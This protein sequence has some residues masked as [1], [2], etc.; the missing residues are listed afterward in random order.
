MEVSQTEK[1][2]TD[3]ESALDTLLSISLKT[4]ASGWQKYQE[5]YN[6]LITK[7]DI[8]NPVGTF[9]AEGEI[10]G[11]NAETLCAY[12]NITE[13]RPNWDPNTKDYIVIKPIRDNYDISYSNNNGALG[14]LITPRDFV[15]I[16][17]IRRLED[18]TI[19]MAGMSID[20]NE[21]PPQSNFIRGHIYP[22]GWVIK[23][24][25]ENAVIVNYITSVDLKG[26]LSGWMINSAISASMIDFFIRLR[27]IFLK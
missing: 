11:V 17:S 15:Q 10:V 13:N 20:F 21:K 8:V 6:I 4:N 18:G 2:I 25:N 27:N 22:S 16:R 5:K 14:G 9:N 3:S 26:S 19:A 12:L 23:P 1:W 7:N 24:K